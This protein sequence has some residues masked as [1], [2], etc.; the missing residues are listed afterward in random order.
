MPATRDL[1]MAMYEAMRER[2]GPQHWWPASTLPAPHDRK[3]EI[4]A[5]AIL[6]QN[7]NWGNVEKALARL[8]AAGRMS[9]GALHALAAK[10]L[11]GLIRPAGY[12][13]VKAKRL[14]NFV[15]HVV[16]GHGGDIEAL[17]AQPAGPLR[18]ELLGIGGV[19]PETADSMILY[20]A[21]KCTFVVDAYTRRVFRRHGLIGE[22]CGYDALKALCESHV[23]AR[24]EL[25]NDYHAQLV[26]VGKACCRPT[27][28]CEGCPLERFPHDSRAGAPKRLPAGRS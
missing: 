2:F 14:K 22:D 7:T 26:A 10:D 13:N 18:A 15:A 6:T 23:P 28:R 19:G 16:E 9:V 1:L 5:G 3:L 21:G 17:L 12:F 11:A 24:V 4:C 20:A 27:A 8:I 25:Y